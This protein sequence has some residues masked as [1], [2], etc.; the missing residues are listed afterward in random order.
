MCVTRGVVQVRRPVRGLRRRLGG[1]RG[2][3]AAGARLP[4]RLAVRRLRL[5]AARLP[6]LQRAL[7][8]APAARAPPAG[9][10]SPSPSR[11]PPLSPTPLD[12]LPPSATNC[13]PRGSSFRALDIFLRNFLDSTICRF[14]PCFPS[15]FERTLSAR[16]QEY[17]VNHFEELDEVTPVTER[18]RIRQQYLACSISVPRRLSMR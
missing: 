11:L 17:Y 15:P 9:D 12:A 3:H 18:R 2:R 13:A 5:R 7:L 14:P 8:H 16:L 6:L 1:R 10:Y 4:G